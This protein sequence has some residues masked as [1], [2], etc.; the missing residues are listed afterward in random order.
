MNN[1]IDRKNPIPLYYQVSELIKQEI[2]DNNYTVGSPLP[3]EE[4]LML[5]YQV[6]R[7]TIREALR[8]L[9]ISGLIDKKQG[10]GTFVGA[11]KI[12]EVLPMLASFSSQMEA[13]GFSVRT[14]VLNVK[15]TV[16]EPEICEVLKLPSGTTVLQVVRRRFVTEKP[17]V[18][19][20]SYMPSSISCNEDFT[21]SLYKI[22]EDKYGYRITGGEAVIE[23][24]IAKKQE[25]SILQIPNG[26]AIL[27]I[28]WTTFDSTNSP[29]EFSESI[30]RADSYSYRVNL[31]LEREMSGKF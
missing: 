20:I 6:S 25:A 11:A 1:T 12:Q 22:F 9:S 23:A 18:Y 21:G 31:H 24:G 28:K 2:Q 13:K 14:E 27:K 16:A 29:I 7:T 19:S 26:D 15:Q 3:T 10:V 4:E 30:Y 5:K 8:L 17:L